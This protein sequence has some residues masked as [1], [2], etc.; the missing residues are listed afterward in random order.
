MNIENQEWDSKNNFL[1]E[2]KSEK[3]QSFIVRVFLIYKTN[4]V[5]NTKRYYRRIK[6]IM[7]EPMFPF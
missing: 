4:I 7:E 6:S 1:I 2:D 5:Y 3:N